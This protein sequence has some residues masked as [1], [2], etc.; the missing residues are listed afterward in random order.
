[1]DRGLAKH[2]C[3][4]ESRRCVGHEPCRRTGSS[5]S[6][7][8]SPRNVAE[9]GASVAASAG[10]AFRYP[11]VT[12][13]LSF[14]PFL[15][16]LPFIEITS[17]TLSVEV[18]PNLSVNIAGQLLF[19][20]EDATAATKSHEF[21]VAAT[22]E[23]EFNVASAVGASAGF[24]IDIGFHLHLNFNFPW[25]INRVE[26]VNIDP[27]IPIQIFPLGSVTPNWDTATAAR[28]V[29]VSKANTATGTFNAAL[30]S[31]SMPGGIGT[32]NPTGFIQACFAP[33]GQPPA[34][35]PQPVHPTP[36]DRTFDQVVL[37]PC[38]VCIGEI[39]LRWDG[40]AN[41]GWPPTDGRGVP[42][43]VKG[44]IQKNIGFIMPSVEPATFKCNRQT[45]RDNAYPICHDL[46]TLDKRTKEMHL[47]ASWRQIA[48][49]YN[50]KFSWRRP[51]PSSNFMG[52]FDSILRASCPD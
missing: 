29:S 50:P 30:D 38:H 5:R 49:N 52:P 34:S 37:F 43:P 7:L 28:G 19:Q 14:F 13:L 2:R 11:D 26:L 31:L 9:T 41:P 48:E 15:D 17:D 10:V 42:S 51:P 8:K 24:G 36:S 22:R 1:M 25:P 27:H 40:S 35:T 39:D 16:D 20:T 23:Q 33:S 32:T 6:D 46:C 21:D 3:A 12:Q 44:N 45:P 4:W 18:R 47:A